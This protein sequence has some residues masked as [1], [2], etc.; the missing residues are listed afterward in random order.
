MKCITLIRGERRVALSRSAAV[1]YTRKCDYQLEPSRIAAED[2]S[3]GLISND[4]FIN[5]RI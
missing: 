5:T 1:T 3:Y 2:D 4:D